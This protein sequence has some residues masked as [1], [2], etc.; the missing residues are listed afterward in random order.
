M[1]FLLNLVLCSLTDWQKLHGFH[2]A[3]FAAFT[4]YFLV[5]RRGVRL[6]GRLVYLRHLDPKRAL[7]EGDLYNVPDLHLIAGLH[8]PAV[9][10][11]AFAV[12]GL[13][14]HGAPLYQA[15]DLKVFVKS[16]MLL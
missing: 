6:V 8:L 3:A 2:R 10:A 14:R 13:V 5:H 12:A 7:P 9:H 11:H 16:H 4:L 15:G 1:L